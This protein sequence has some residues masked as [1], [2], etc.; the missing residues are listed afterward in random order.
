[1]HHWAFAARQPLAAG[2]EDV[3]VRTPAM[4]S[5]RASVTRTCRSGPPTASWATLRHQWPSGANS[6]PSCCRCARFGRTP[7]ARFARA[8]LVPQALRERASNS[9]DRWMGRECRSGNSTCVLPR[10]RRPS[11]CWFLFP[12]T[13]CAWLRSSLS[14]IRTVSRGVPVTRRASLLGCPSSG[15]RRYPS[16]QRG[17]G[18]AANTN[19][20]KL[21]RLVA[22]AWIHYC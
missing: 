9:I 16:D 13:R 4:L 12:S 17:G 15:I 19:V 1:M 20:P 8:V 5:A 14:L 10:R 21:A 6:S 3:S 11:A 22:C 18:K 2:A 7:S